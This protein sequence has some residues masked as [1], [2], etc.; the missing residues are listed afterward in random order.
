MNL[1]PF[2]GIPY[3]NRGSSYAGCDCWGL[4][5][6]F[7]A[8]ILGNL[9]PRY[10]GYGDATKP[11]ISSYISDRWNSWQ[12]VRLEDIQIGDIIALNLNGLPVHCA[13][14]VGR[15]KMLHILDG[16]MSCTETVVSG[17]WK[18]SIA[19]IGRWKS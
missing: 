14:Y 5:W 19:R 12:Q 1:N 15:G 8:D 10:E 11:E 2:I 18:N 3:L 6:L 16:R 13:V 9:L 17:F 7:H 4:V